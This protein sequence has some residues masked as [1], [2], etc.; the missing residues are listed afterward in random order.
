LE[1]VAEMEAAMV[2]L[3]EL[4]HAERSKGTRVSE[5]EAALADAAEQHAGEAARLQAALGAATHG[6][7]GAQACALDCSC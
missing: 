1:R 5:L 2:E 3:E 7:K 6:E 4:R